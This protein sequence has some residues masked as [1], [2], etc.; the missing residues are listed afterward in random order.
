MAGITPIAQLTNGTQV[1]L[2]NP[3]VYTPDD[4]AEDKWWNHVLFGTPAPTSTPT[5]LG[6]EE[7]QKRAHVQAGANAVKS[8]A[9][10]ALG[11][12]QAQLESTIRGWGLGVGLF[13]LAIVLIGIGG[14]VLLEA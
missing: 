5:N 9:S 11:I 14:K 3:F 7:T 10:N 13:L 12:N 6:P 2:T 1:A 8:A 4:A